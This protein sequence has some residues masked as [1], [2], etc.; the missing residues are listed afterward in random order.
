MYYE[1]RILNYK[2]W[3]KITDSCHTFIVCYGLFAYEK[4]FCLFF[5]ARYGNK[6]KPKDPA[7]QTMHYCEVCK[8]S[9]AGAVVSL[10]ALCCSAMQAFIVL[11]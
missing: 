9:C 4:L 3:T 10:R 11:F 1:L 8:V 5:A 2:F 7:N 6:D